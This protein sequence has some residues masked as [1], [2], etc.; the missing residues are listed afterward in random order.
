[1]EEEGYS[2]YDVYNVDETGA[3]WKDLPRKSLAPKRESSAPGFKVSK[4]RVT[5]MGKTFLIMADL[6]DNM[7]EV[8]KKWESK[9]PNFS[10]RGRRDARFNSGNQSKGYNRN[11]YQDNDHLIY[12]RPA[13]RRYKQR[14]KFPRF[15]LPKYEGLAQFK[16]APCVVTVSKQRPFVGACCLK[17]LPMSRNHYPHV[18]LDVIQN[19]KI[20]HD[21]EKIVENYQKDESSAVS[22][23]IQYREARN[24]LESL[25]TSV[26]STC[27]QVTSF[28]FHYVFN[29][30]FSG[31]LVHKGQIEI[32]KA[33]KVRNIPF[34][35][36]PL[37]RSNLD[38]VLI[39][40]I[41][42]MNSLKVPLVTVDH[43][44][45]I[46]VIGWLTR[47]LGALYIRKYYECDK[48]KTDLIQSVMIQRY[49]SECLK[50]GHNLE[51][52]L[53]RSHSKSDKLP[54]SRDLLSFVIDAVAEETVDDVLIST[55][56]I[57]YEKIMEENFATKQL[58]ESKT[59]GNFFTKLYNFWKMLHFNLGTVR[60]NFGQPFSLRVN[61]TCSTSLMSTQ[62]V[63]FL[64]ITKYRKGATQQQLQNSLDWLCGEL[65]NKKY[66]AGFIGESLPVIK[67][68]VELLGKK[69]ISSETVDMEWTSSDLENNN[70]KVTVYKPVTQLPHVLE[71]Q[72]YSNYVVPV[73]LLDSMIAN[74][75]YA[76]VDV[77]ICHFRHCDSKLYIFKEDV[78]DKAVELSEMLQFEFIAVAPCSD[79][80]F[81]FSDIIDELIEKDCL[82]VAGLGF[83]PNRNVYGRKSHHL[84][85]YSSED[86]DDDS[87]LKKQQLKINLTEE[88]INHLEFLR[89]V[90]SPCIESYWLGA[91]TLLKLI[92]EIMEE[93]IL[94][95]EM[96]LTAQE[97]LYKGLLAY[98]ESFS[99]DTFRNA[100][101]LFE[102]WQIVEHYVQDGIKVVY[103]SDSW[104]SKERIND[105]I[106]RIEEFRK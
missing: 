55:V 69:L 65:T 24:I 26:C 78:L 82:H 8:Y 58:G 20:N 7:K 63:S 79:I 59:Q 84:S 100:L 28:F 89:S 31:I 74:A 34:V 81:S 4:E 75:L 101:R 44:L 99:A 94:I 96:Q 16:M 5:A 73:F 35:Y 102:L 106:A 38:Y 57:S 66:D 60:I 14:V 72:Y 49:L 9:R 23:C 53:K 105:V 68:A 104:N 51:F 17:C 62:L 1:M 103:L 15:K 93:N 36:L 3:N 61:A 41:L 88:S 98:E 86:E 11:E 56:S 54:L 13:D 92:D 52:F 85:F 71:L 47:F 87:V 37:Y 12:D 43:D 30:I 76:L 70:V 19:E 80:M 83:M 18:S 27:L 64:F 77:E 6:I 39:S 2:R 91:V 29:R 46:P 67:R 40:F 48:E 21:V 32:K 25:K 50:L 33:K 22:K 95:Q 90:L 45:Y 42:Y 10:S 97:K